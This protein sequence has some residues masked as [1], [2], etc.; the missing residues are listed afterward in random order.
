MTEP[1]PF[2]RQHH[3]L[4]SPSIDDTS[5]RPYWRVWTRLDQLLADQAIGPVVW[6]AGVGFRRLQ[7]I[8][9]TDQ[10]KTPNLEYVGSGGG[11][12]TVPR[13]LDALKAVALVRRE[14]GS[15][16]VDLLELHL[17]ADLPWE[18]LGQQYGVHRKTA[19]NWTIIC[20]EMLAVV[21][22]QRGE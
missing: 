5:F 16:A 1:S 22:W 3:A 15:F 14:I 18:R 6:R 13:R 9:V 21:L 4:E 17:V 2:F 7:E 11:D 8:V 10:W 12:M 20:L 19:R